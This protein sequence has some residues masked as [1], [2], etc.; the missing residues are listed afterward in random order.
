[1]EH[2]NYIK[3]ANSE[4]RIIRNE[5]LPFVW[6]KNEQQKFTISIKQEQLALLDTIAMQDSFS[7]L[8]VITSVIATTLTH[9]HYQSGLRVFTPPVLGGSLHVPV[10]ISVQKDST[11]KAAMKST[12]A[13]LSDSYNHSGSLDEESVHLN[14]HSILIAHA[15]IHT[16]PSENSDYGL[17]INIERG[18]EEL[19][20]TGI[21][22]CANA[23]LVNQFKEK[24]EHVLAQLGDREQ[25]LKDLFSRNQAVNADTPDEGEY[26]EPV[27]SRTLLKEFSKIVLAYPGAP[28]LMDAE[29]SYSYLELDAWSTHTA[30]CLLRDFDVRK[31]EPVAV[32]LPRNGSWISAM[33][34]VL[35]A[36]AVY[37]P[38]DAGLPLKRIEYILK[39]ANVNVVIVNSETK[40]LI[41]GS[42][43]QLHEVDKAP[44]DLI[45]DAVAREVSGSD[46]AYMIYTSGSSGQPS[47]VV[48]HHSGIA[49]TCLDQISRFGIL[50]HDRVLAFASASFDAS[51]YEL[52]IALLSGAGLVIHDRVQLSASS[53]VAFLNHYQVS[54]CVLPPVY[55]HELKKAGLPYLKTLVT[56]GEKAIA[57]DAYHYAATLNYYNAYGPTEC[58]VCATVYKVGANSSSKNIPIGKPI[59]NTRVSVLNEVSEPC[60]VGGIGEIWIE[61]IGVASGYLDKMTKT[62]S[63]FYDSTLHK[64]LYAYK[65]GDMGRYLPDG[66]LEFLWRVDDQVK[67]Q[68]NRIALGELNHAAL[69]FEGIT[70]VYSLVNENKL[71]TFYTSEKTIEEEEYRSF[72]NEWLPAYMMPSHFIK[73]PF[74]PLTANGKIDASELVKLYQSISSEAETAEMALS[75]NEQVIAGIWKEV[76][77]VEVNKPS[78]N[79]FHLGGHSLDAIKIVSMLEERF[80]II[81][82]IT[83]VFDKPE[84]SEFSKSLVFGELPVE[85]KVPDDVVGGEPGFTPLS[86]TQKQFWIN[87][88]LK[89]HTNYT[90]PFICSL[91]GS[92]NTDLLEKA[93]RATI[94][95]N[96]ILRTCFIEQD[97]EPVQSVLEEVPFTLEKINRKGWYK[98]IA[99]IEK[100]VH[101]AALSPFDLAVP[102][103]FRISV[104][105]LDDAIHVLSMQVHHIIMDA[106]SLELWFKQ[107]FKAYA[108]GLGEKVLLAGKAEPGGKQAIHREQAGISSPDFQEALSYWRKQLNDAEKP[109]LPWKKTGMLSGNQSSLVRHYELDAA[110]VSEIKMLASR[111]SVTLFNF[112]LAS[113]QGLLSRLTDQ[114]ASI[115]G[116][117]FSGR[118]QANAGQ[119][120]NFVNLLPI[121]SDAGDEDT[122]LSLVHQVKQALYAADKYQDIPMM[123]IMETLGIEEEL[124]DLGF[125][126]HTES[127]VASE[128]EGLGISAQP[129]TMQTSYAKYPLWIYGTEKNGSVTL[130][131]EY[132]PELFDTAHIDRW[133]F[134]WQRFIH[135]LLDA[136]AT[137][138]SR[139][140]LLPA[141]ESETLRRIA[142]A[143]HTVSDA[144]TIISVFEEQLAVNGDKCAL[145]FENETYTYHHL[146]A[147]ANELAYA[148]MN[149]YG[150]KAGNNVALLLEKSP[151]MYI[152]IL[153]VLKAGCAYVP[154]YVDSTAVQ[155]EHVLSQSESVLMITTG[156]NTSVILQ[157][158]MPAYLI[159][160]QLS[161]TGNPVNPVTERK[162]SDVAYVMF[163]SGTTGNPK[164]VAVEHRS[165][166]R[167]VKESNFF[168]LH[169]GDVGMNIANYSFDGSVTEIFGTFLNGATLVVP[170]EER[171]TLDELASL[172]RKHHVN[173]LLF[174]TTQLFNQ[175]IDHQPELIRLFN[176]IYFGGE[177]A[178]VKHIQ[179]AIT[180]RK[181]EDSLVHVY[182]PTEGTVYSSYYTV[183]SVGKDQLYLPIGRAVSGTYIYIL[184]H[185]LNHLPLGLTGEL[186]IG[187]TGLAKGYL[188]DEEQTR[189]KFIPDP[190]RNGERLYR[191]GDYGYWNEEQ[192]LVFVKRKDKQVKIRGYRVEL[193]YLEN[194]LN[195]CPGIDKALVVPHAGSGDTGLELIAYMSGENADNTELIRRFLSAEIPGYMIPSYFIKVD[196]F[197]LNKNG[198]INLKALP[199]PGE[200][201]SRTIVLPQSNTELVVSEIWKDVLKVKEISTDSDF[202]ETGGNSIKA[203]KVISLI[204]E[205]L[206]VKVSITAFFNA[207]SIQEI[208]KHIDARTGLHE[209]DRITPL[210][211]SAGYAASQAQKRLWVNQEIN[212]ASSKYTVSVVYGLHGKPDLLQVERVLAQLIERHECLRTSFHLVN[213]ELQ[214]VVHSGVTPPLEHITHIDKKEIDLFLASATRRLFDFK[215]APL[216]EVKIISFSESDHVLL[217]NIHHIISDEWSFDIL[218]KE[219]ITLL[220]LKDPM[221][222][223]GLE[224]IQ[225][226]YKDY[227]AWHNHFLE[228]ESGKQQEAY[229][230]SKLGD[231]AR[232]AH[233][234][235][236]KTGD[237]AS[238]VGV[239]EFEVSEPVA[240]A[241]SGYC[242]QHHATVFMGIISVIKIVLQKYT[243]KTDLTIGIPVAGREQQE[244][245]NLVGFFV[246]M[247]TIRTAA[248]PQQSFSDLLSHV[249]ANTIEAM[250]NQ[251]YPYDLLVDK[252]GLKHK[253]L[254]KTGLTWHNVSEADDKEKLELDGMTFTKKASNA[255]QAFHELWFFGMEQEQK[256]K[257][258]IRYDTA[259]YTGKTIEGLAS[260]MQLVI[261]EMLLNPGMLIGD[262][263]LNLPGHT[264]KEESIDDIQFN[265]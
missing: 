248:S 7:E 172:V 178:S 133:F 102:P 129:Y 136:P 125:T 97:E 261:K 218:F 66:N 252:I 236:D 120:G 154:V 180:Y 64:G 192:Q 265:F 199:L 230:L 75:A 168:K 84:L 101:A 18:R 128:L 141:E 207:P 259:R 61:G 26:A 240:K 37:L 239:V 260:N 87:E 77:G 9:Y 142:F 34:A 71:L 215:T 203:I 175:L 31:G 219:F 161:S 134:Y 96:E 253:D 257:F 222:P 150:V 155:I 48:V 81:C 131:F 157:F 80:G 44:R 204:Q 194:K 83:D 95:E 46:G 250:S 216:F 263:T 63:G 100:E 32:M 82:H 193:L 117:P 189:T 159:D 206:S 167:L 22:A 127:S 99:D 6:E 151:L 28:A 79:F 123:E 58:A 3:T 149:D 13:A 40:A 42:G 50:P 16:A 208:S 19:N 235:Y 108:S 106:W 89:E 143:D 14:E 234:P 195:G 90:I 176:R 171:L 247:L 51:L 179:K 165:V 10:F 112:L 220:S 190:Y 54:M 198:K 226:H 43:Y 201:G 162:S 105:E 118:S 242:Q 254:F 17:W 1:M 160:V 70:E 24:T 174:I 214:Q 119:L 182:G 191:T 223:A 258:T 91:S 211:L 209:Q 94:K 88:R 78:D 156:K 47:G 29:K 181:W 227:S 238:E 251:Q 5:L 196:E 221:A 45:N 184:D 72:L 68:G 39:N 130:S 187:G 74:F 52:F 110:V 2:W 232:P 126:W 224:A 210:P 243:G 38:V 65:T 113:L 169:S 30:N 67:V 205:R 35:K 132:T 23:D 177:Q 185:H 69:Q 229:W 228:G 163:T 147:L 146:N 57:E 213:G 4:N 107:I 98:T 15:G 33:L 262:L 202:F 164:A 249:A 53:F 241:F 158:A 183:G 60:P 27:K 115:L 246:N 186:Y 116:V 173:N 85:E 144:H 73:L 103:L 217:F 153:G 59:S 122:F 233:F 264:V 237:D 55:L 145:I 36:G 188:H 212:K 166:V 244:L 225:I 109:A 197:P 231:M 11:L 8:A 140:D 41:A 114:P 104:Y 12:A 124:F 49:N 135:C 148:L 170:E 256:M 111:Q 62:T 152:A 139:I 137:P 25:N 76:I 20:I 245:A 121:K 255:E 138:L 92:L 56:A 86:A 200:T 93:I 21:F